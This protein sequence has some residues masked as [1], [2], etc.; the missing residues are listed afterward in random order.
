MSLERR[1]RVNGK[2]V[3]PDRFNVRFCVPRPDLVTLDGEKVAVAF[4]CTGWVPDVYVGADTTTLAVPTLRPVNVGAT[5]GFVWPAGTTTVDGE[6]VSFELSLDV[7]V[8]VTGTAGALGSV[9][10][11][12]ALAPRATFGLGGST[13]APALWT[14]ASSMASVTV[15]ALA[16]I[17]AAPTPTPVTGI[18]TLMELAGNVT[19]PGTVAIS[20]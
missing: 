2:A 3:T 17:F 12:G 9:N 1:A 8:T 7:R 4:T 6:I 11:K 20:G 16:C 15:G 10:D 5:D 18:P 13:I 14:V 19:L